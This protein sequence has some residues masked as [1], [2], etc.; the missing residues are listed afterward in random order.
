MTG[1][2]LIISRSLHSREK[3]I[4][5]TGA[6]IVSISFLMLL[7]ALAGYTYLDEERLK[8]KTPVPL[9]E[10][11]KEW[12]KQNSDAF[13]VD[14]GYDIPPIAFFEGRSY[15]G[16]AI[17]YAELIGKKLK[18]NFKTVL[19]SSYHDALEKIKN[20]KINII[21]GMQKTPEREKFFNF[22]T[23]YLT[24]PVVIVRRKNS[25]FLNSLCDLKGKKVAIPR[26]SFVISLLKKEH[27]EI[28]IIKYNGYLQALRQVSYGHSDAAVMNRSI[29][30]FLI[31]REIMLNLIIGGDTPWTNSFSFAVPKN[32]P[33]MFSIISKAM[34]AIPSAQKEAIQHR[35]FHTGSS[36]L[37]KHKTF[38]RSALIFAII[39]L[40]A[41]LSVLLWN[42]FLRRR[43]RQQTWVIHE[44]LQRKKKIEKELSHS[45]SEYRHLFKKSPVGIFY[46][47]T[48]LRLLRFNDYFSNILHVPAEKL[49]LLHMTTLKDTRILPTL[50]A[51][52]AGEEGLYEGPYSVTNS[53]ASPRLR[54]KTA[55]LH[56]E[57][58]E[59]TGAVG[60]VE[61]ITDE[62]LAAEKIQQQNEELKT[63]NMIREQTN[64]DLIA[65]NEELEAMNAQILNSHE[66]L[67][68]QEILYRSIFEGVAD[69]L[70]IFD[71]HYTIRAANT[72]ALDLLGYD[73]K[74]IK[75]LSV[76]AI[77]DQEVNV[78]SALLEESI[79]K[80]G[81]FMKKI[82]QFR[83]DGSTFPAEV[84]GSIIRFYGEDHYL[85]VIRDITE[86]EQTEELILQ[87]EKMH[88]V[89]SLAAGMAHEINNPLGIIIQGVQNIERRLLAD[90]PANREKAE[91]IGIDFT[92]LNEYCRERGIDR[93]FS[94]IREA[95]E[96][97]SKI[98]KRL[99]DFSIRGESSTA[100][101]SINK[102][103]EESIDLASKDYE[104]KKKYKFNSIKITTDLSPENPATVAVREDLEQVFLHL[105]RNAVQFMAQKTWEDTGPELIISTGIRDDNVWIRIEDSGPGIP[106][107]IILKIFDPFFTTLDVGAG[108]G[109]GLSVAYFIIAE[110]HNGQISI[111][112]TGPGGTTFLIELPRAKGD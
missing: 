50:K 32:R 99:I 90:I 101:V 37:Q 17:D 45:R 54:L 22:T 48:G 67:Q 52:F 66:E 10:N 1:G 59:I 8:N 102:I 39:A 36:S 46:Y 64:E 80:T 91:N 98:I 71:R 11:E 43:V 13:T 60:I 14:A 21:G 34:N 41:A 87:S 38:F 100:L 106:P 75:H 74:E 96:R 112:K 69:A 2:S 40:F 70:I 109:L 83:R 18:I 30:F 65:A 42:F 77:M 35:W 104:L 108:T 82:K 6:G 24:S 57:S 78:L 33:E 3:E 89:G 68:E 49:K 105:I 107:E 15:Q 53:D 47:D 84:R 73:R 51:P 7:L 19:V 28:R 97:A 63:L 31:E 103:L 81:Q 88:T 55:P 27:P 76:A 26:N 79:K 23:P 25:P 111:E 9:T 56:G 20:G 93:Y 29:A 44:E 92:K 12:L 16:V 4:S 62:M 95:G 85:A 110:R 86:R 5:R 94:G 72:A 58:G 61:D